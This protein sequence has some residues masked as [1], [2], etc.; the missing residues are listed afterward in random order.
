LLPFAAGALSTWPTLSL[1]AW[2]ETALNLSEKAPFPYDLW[3]WVAGVGLREELSKLA[4]FALFL[5]WLL[6]R[7]QPGLALMT[8]AFVGLGFA[9]DENIDYYH[10]FGGAVSVVRFLTA[11]FLHLAWTG[12]TAHAL[13]ELVRSR[14]AT[15][16]RFIV[17]FFAIVA[18]HGLY[19]YTPSSGE[20][21][22]MSYIQLL[23]LVL[24]AH[25]FLEA[26]A[27]ECVPSRQVIAPPAVFLVG[28]A[29]LVAMA[30]WV[31]AVK[32]H[33]TAGLA[34]VGMEAVLTLPLGVVYW[35]RLG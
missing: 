32:H 13:Y 29:A 3:Y 24:A 19:D 18:A 28:T 35:R 11:N 22:G 7:R 23:L 27:R 10:D 21:D 34:A 17:T 12:I 20:M 14:F 25:Q 1:G 5:P 2:Q 33:S 16:E 15:A 9:F 6:K 30:F 8:G 26:A 31:S 4:L